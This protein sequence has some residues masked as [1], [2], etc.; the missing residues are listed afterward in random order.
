[1]RRRTNRTLKALIRILTVL[2]WV[3]IRF[4]RLGV[5]DYAYV[6]RLPSLEV[7][8]ALPHRVK[9]VVKPSEDEPMPKLGLS[10]TTLMIQILLSRLTTGQF[11]LSELWQKLGNPV[12]GSHHQSP[13]SS[14]DSQP[15][16]W[17]FPCSK[18][19]SQSLR[20]RRSLPRLLPELFKRNE[21]APVQLPK[22]L[23][24]VTRRTTYVLTFQTNSS[25]NCIYQ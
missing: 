8:A 19:R 16:W 6:E 2:W 14:P 12:V 4:R 20:S 15:K 11:R 23:E 9:D 13:W 18:N 1:M 25:K 10:T 22:V 21:L 3:D 7:I 24:P 5:G 17:P